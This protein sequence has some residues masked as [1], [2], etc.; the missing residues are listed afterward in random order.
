MIP[1]KNRGHRSTALRDRTGLPLPLAILMDDSRNLLRQTPTDAVALTGRQQPPNTQANDRISVL[2]L[3]LQQARLDLRFWS[4]ILRMSQ[5]CPTPQRMRL[6]RIEESLTI[7]THRACGRTH[8]ARGD[9]RHRTGRPATRGIRP[10][11][12]A[13]AQGIRQEPRP[14]P[15]GPRPKPRLNAQHSPT[16]Q[17]KTP[18]RRFENRF[19]ECTHVLAVPGA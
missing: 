10:K 6:E 13:G 12:R 3:M 17:R 1:P 11:P 18:R 7:T 19:P 4:F 9:D 2:L 5:Q 15:Q 16:H 14:H 8:R